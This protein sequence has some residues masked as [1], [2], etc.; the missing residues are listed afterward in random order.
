MLCFTTGRGSVFGC[1]PAPLLKLATNTQ[2]YRRMR[3]D[4][5]INCGTIIDGQA[6]VEEMGRQIFERI[7]ATASG[8]KT[9]SELLG[10]GE[11]EF[12]PWTVGAIL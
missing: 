12:V 4:M 3:D 1:K 7:L 2:M 8:E 6:T 11:N 10:M 5:D 9:R